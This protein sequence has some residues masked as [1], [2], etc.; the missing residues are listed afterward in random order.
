MSKDSLK[1]PSNMRRK[2]SHDDHFKYLPRVNSDQAMYEV[3]NNVYQS[4][5]ILGHGAFG[6]VIL[7]EH[8]RT[9]EKYSIRNLTKNPFFGN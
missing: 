9:K 3:Y 5:K 8:I 6:Y 1:A 4:K 7:V 2:R